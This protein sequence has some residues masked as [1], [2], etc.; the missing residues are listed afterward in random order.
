MENRPPVNIMI[1]DDAAVVRAMIMRRLKEEPHY[2][3][4]ASV[5]NGEMAVTNIK[6]NKIDVVILDI[7][8]PVMDGMTALPKL[9]EISPDTKV[10]MASTLTLRNADISLKALERGAV[11]YIPKPSVKEDKSALEKFYD[12]LVG[13]IEAVAAAKP[14]PKPKPADP[15]VP[16][17]EKE[18]TNMIARRAAQMAL[19]SAPKSRPEGSINYPSQ[20]PHAIAIAASTGGPQALTQ[21]FKALKGKLPNVP[22]FITQHMPPT[23]TQILAKHISDAC[24]RDCH[25]ATQ[26]EIVKPDGIYLAPGDYHMVPYMKGMDVAIHLNQDEEVNY[27]RPA[28]DPMIDGLVN[29]YGKSLML[30]VLTGMGHDGFEGAKKLYQMGGTVIA[31]DRE[32]SVVWGMPKAVSDNNVC[33]AV[34]PL[35]QIPD[36][37]LNAFGG[38]A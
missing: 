31:Q 30:L 32:T 6:N 36:Y 19:Q 27:C 20:M 12:D 5:A 17:A 14:Q 9:L 37:V 7:E 35:Q 25:E 23:F 28:A 22:I 33:Q 13:K 16:I 26:S 29:V 21:L 15:V 2:N 11:D 24:G 38:R 4:V 8:M 1:V 10:I 18:S 34:L 3:I